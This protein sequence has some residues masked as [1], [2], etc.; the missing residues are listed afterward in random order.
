ME[1][2]WM[3]GGQQRAVEIQVLGRPG[4]AIPRFPRWQAAPDRSLAA[5]RVARV[6]ARTDQI[7]LLRPAGRLHTTPPR[8][9]DQ[10][11]LEN[12]AGLP[13]TQGGVGARSL[14]GSQ[15]ARVA[16]S[17]HSSDDGA[18]VSHAGNP[19]REKKLLGG[20]CRGRVVSFS[21]CCAHGPVSV[22]T[23]ARRVMSTRDTAH[24]YL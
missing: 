3:A 9:L 8:P 11:P 12:R 18:S 19:P 23:A 7:F 6:R 1:D 15:L 13:T 10:V 14:R 24:N 17:R 4:T 16:P 22:V 20:P 21:T 5:G 2:D